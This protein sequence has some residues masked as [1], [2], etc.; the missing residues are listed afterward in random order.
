MEEKGSNF[1]IQKPPSVDLDSCLL[2]ERLAGL[3]VELVD[4][5]MTSGVHLITTKTYTEVDFF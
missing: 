3:V 4:Y 2:V 5:Y 1:S